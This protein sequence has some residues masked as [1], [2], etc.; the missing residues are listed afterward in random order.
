MPVFCVSIFLNIVGAKMKNVKPFYDVTLRELLVTMSLQSASSRKGNSKIS[1]G[2]RTSP[3][4][5]S[6][7]ALRSMKHSL[8]SV[9]VSSLL[10]DD[11]VPADRP[12]ILEMTTT[13][14]STPRTPE[15]MGKMRAEFIAS[16]KDAYGLSAYCYVLEYQSRGVPHLHWIVSFPSKYRRAIDERS[17]YS[18][19]KNA[20]RRYQKIRMSEQAFEMKVLRDYDDVS[21][22]LYYLAKEYSKAGMTL[23]KPRGEARWSYFPKLWQ[24]C[25]P[26]LEPIK[27]SLSEDHEVAFRRELDAINSI[28]N[29]KYVL[30]DNHP[31]Y[32]VF[33]RSVFIPTVDAKMDLLV[34]TDPDDESMSVTQWW[35]KYVPA[36]SDER[37][38]DVL[39]TWETDGYPSVD[40]A[41]ELSDAVDAHI[42]SCDTSDNSADNDSAIDD[43]SVTLSE[44]SEVIDVRGDSSSRLMSSSGAD[45]LCGRLYHSVCALCDMDDIFEEIFSDDSV[46]TCE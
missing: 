39:T 24:N 10:M 18:M 30:P 21:S 25:L 15:M 9:D 17:L 44:V 12:L 35:D 8:F 4:T 23:P 6:R 28:V 45:H 3:V 7:S 43:S 2:G 5:W 42:D 1:N 19:W 29:G 36:F 31:F 27:A 46:V 37:F 13:L 38:R 11:L 34:A 32:E 40:E 20:V 14:G 26:I 33:G 22:A 16:M 41:K